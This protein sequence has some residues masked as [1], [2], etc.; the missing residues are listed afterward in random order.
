[1]VILAKDV[2]KIDVL[3]SALKLQTASVA[4]QM[5][6]KRLAK[7]VFLFYRLQSVNAGAF[8]CVLSGFCM[9]KLFFFFFA[10]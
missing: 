8:A 4:A 3:I 6:S 5:C 2:A 9:N 10:C 1:M 7:D